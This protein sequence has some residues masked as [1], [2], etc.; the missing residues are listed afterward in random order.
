MNPVEEGVV[1]QG[2][3]PTRARRWALALMVG[4]ATLA[5]C[6]KTPVDNPYLPLNKGRTWT[7]SLTSP[8]PLGG[9]QSGTMQVTSLGKLELG[10]KTVTKE[11]VQV[12]GDTRVLYIAVDDR[13]VYRHA[14]KSSEDAEPIIEAAPAY[15]LDYPL[16]KDKTWKGRVHPTLLELDVSIPIESTVESTNATVSVPAGEFTACVKIKTIG[17]RELPP[18]T[19]GGPPGALFVSETAW[20]AKNVGLVKSEL[21]EK[22]NVAAG[23]RTMSLTTALTG[24]T[25]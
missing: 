10:G 18:A 14:A 20:Y 4:A 7:Y 1:M 25:Q 8:A 2:M 21:E 9:A 22:L 15:V 16:Q 11:R 19:N 5:A 24:S 6:E 3:L 13:G 23:S 17:S 12:G